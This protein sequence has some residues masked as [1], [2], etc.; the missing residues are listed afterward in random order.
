MAAESVGYAVLLT[1]ID[2]PIAWRVQFDTTLTEA[3]VAIL[4]PDECGA[5]RILVLYP[6][7]CEATGLTM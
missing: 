6:N 5:A 1:L 4:A 7:D 3:D 2:A